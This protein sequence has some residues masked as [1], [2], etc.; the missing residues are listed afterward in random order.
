MDSE[1]VVFVAHQDQE[2]LGV[3]YLS[4][5]LLSNKIVSNVE[6]IDFRLSKEEICEKIKKADPLLVGFSLIFQY[7]TFQLRDLVEYLRNNGV[8]C[9]FTVGGHYPS[10]RFEDILKIIPGIDSVVRFEGEFTICELAEN[11]KS[12]NDWTRIKG[13]AHHKT[14]Q[15][16]SNELRPLISDLDTLPFPKRNKKR[17]YKCMGKDSVFILASRGC[18]YNCGFC[19]IRQFYGI[20]PGKLRRSRTPSNVVKEM[21]SL[22]EKFKAR[23]FL[24]QDDDFLQ[25]KTGKKWIMDFL[26]ELEKEGLKNKILWKISCRSDEIDFDL[27]SQM[28]EHGLCLA[29]LGIESGNQKGLI[30]LNKKLTVDDHFRAVKILKEL[31]ILYDYGF[32]LFNPWSTFETLLEDISFLRK[33]CGDGSSPVVFCKTIPYA[34]TGIE[35]K[36]IKDGRLKG[37]II[38]PDYD[39]LDPRLDHLCKWLHQIFQ[40]QLFSQAGLSAELRFHRLEIAVLEKFYPQAKSVDKYKEF[41][42]TI[43]SSFNSIFFDVVEKSAKI[44]KE[45]YEPEIQLNRLV[46]SQLK[47]MQL[48]DQKLN[49]GMEDFLRN[50]GN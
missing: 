15:P 3:S 22:Y 14:G 39:L 27:F 38:N 1:K 33:M 30:Y 35:K 28:K 43:V 44:F 42:S 19:S 24:F 13:L 37:S 40:G 7:H 41:L 18:I 9:H 36:L 17:R 25:G 45:S 5:M 34:E 46:E 48:I 21:K 6:I 20:P 16:F 2:N 26:N 31:Q 50:Q 29:Y 23:I 11:L 47:E 4:S 49:Q 10:L 12:N 32:M 8:S